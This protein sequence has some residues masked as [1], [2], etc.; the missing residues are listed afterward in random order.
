VLVEG[1]FEI[2]LEKDSV[3]QVE[4]F[5]DE[6]LLPFIETFISGKELNV[7]SS[8]RL[9]SKEKIR[10]VVSY[11]TLR[12]IR[13]TGAAVLTSEE[14]IESRE[15][16]L[17]MEGAGVL[18]LEIQVQFLEHHLSGAG[19]VNLKGMADHAD[20]RLSGAGGLDAQN[21][22]VQHCDITVSGIGGA[23]LNVKESLKARIE[24]IGG[25]EYTG[26]PGK[27]DKVVTGIGRIGKINN[28]ESQKE[29]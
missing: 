22:E 19:L 7:I 29:I 12:E 9:I 17:N 8:H 13:I 10:I 27:I 4:I 1:G 5:T 24:G 16:I 6:N 14:V 28:E 23:K 18:E 21:L 3:F 26:E 2:V 11:D 25:I 15:L 20:I